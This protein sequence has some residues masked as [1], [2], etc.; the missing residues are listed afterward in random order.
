MRRIA[1]L[2]LAATMTACSVDSTSPSGSVAGTYELR[3]INGELLPYTFG[4]GVTLISDQLIL[5]RDGTYVDQSQ[6][7]TGTEYSD[8][9][10]YTSRGG[11]ITFESTANNVTYQ[12]SLSGSTL[13]VITTNYTQV[14]QR[15]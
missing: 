2:A 1:M 11:S 3:R 15:Q 12:G 9:G 8:E 6:Y 5:Y 14:F 10:Y 7:D 13:T 4:N